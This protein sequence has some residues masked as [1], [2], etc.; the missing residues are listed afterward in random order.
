[1]AE[2]AK[3]KAIRAARV[4]S[5]LTQE[6]AADILGV[7]PPTYI[8]REK[9]PKAFTIDELEDLFV[10]FDDEGKRI[11]QNFVRDIFLLQ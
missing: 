10:K 7:S 6:Q 5:G 1:M 3:S 4:I 11:V 9:A 8:S 2:S